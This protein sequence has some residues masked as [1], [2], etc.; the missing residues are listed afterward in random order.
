MKKIVLAALGSVSA[1]IA[2]SPAQSALLVPGG[3]ATF[4][5]FD[6]ATQGDELDSM[7]VSGA[8]PTVAGTLRS[9]V[10]R[11]IFGTLDFYYQVVH[12]GGDPIQRI[13][14]A[15]FNIFTTFAYFWDGDPDAGGPEG[16]GIFTAANN[17]REVAGTPITFVP[18][19]TPAESTATRSLDG[20]VLSVNFQAPPGSPFLMNPVG[21]GQ[22]SSTYIFR[23]NATEYTI[24]T[25]GVIDG[26]AFSVAAFAPVPEP[27]TWAMMLV[28]FGAV[29]YSMRRRPRYRLVQAV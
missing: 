17:P 25:G 19:V 29:G 9:A 14:A 8:A 2:V 16:D 5:P 21:P 11:N 12:N 13:T 24:G 10:F 27:S 4:D 28:G 26:T 3:I 20:N 7:Q 18:G 15:P 6:V 22:T 1:F 23:T